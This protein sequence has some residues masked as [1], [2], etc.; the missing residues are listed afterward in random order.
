MDDIVITDLSNRVLE[1]L[2]RSHLSDKTIWEYKRCGIRPILFFFQENGWAA[3]SAEAVKDL[4]MREWEKVKAGLLPRY[5]WSILRR[6]SVYLEQMSM[7]GILHRE[8]LPKWE[9]EIGINPLW[10]AADTSPER[11]DRIETVIQLTRDEVWKLDLGEKAKTNYLFS[12]F[13]IILKYFS[14]QGQTEYSQ[15][16]L[17]TCVRDVRTRFLKGEVGRSSFQCVRKTANW[18]QEYRNTGAITHCRLTNAAFTYTNPEYEELLRE[19]K[20]YMDS[21][22]Y[23]K[24]TT[25][26]V[27]VLEVRRFFRDL[28]EL[29]HTDYASLCLSDVNECIAKIVKETE[30]SIFM[31][32]IAMRSFASFISER[33]P[34][35]PDITPA[36]NCT[37]VRHRRV[38]EGYTDEEA[39]KILNAIDR[40]CAQGKRDYA[41]IMIAY[42]TGMR[43]IDIV[44][45]RFS[46]IDWNKREF[47]IVQEKTGKPLALPFDT[48][49]G[50][51]I[52]DYI[53]NA[54][55]KCDS[56]YVFIRTVRPYKK[57]SGMW[58]IVNVYA[59]AALGETG[60]MNGPHSFRRGMGQRLIEAGISGSVVCDVMGHTSEKS[61]LQYTSASMESLRQCCRTL[62]EIPVEQ[63]AL[64]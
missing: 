22:G 56:E 46:S 37:P 62:S 61:L 60:K 41:M 31:E 24:E 26:K 11:A 63:E 50:N 4:V 38:Y 3:Y 52:A 43:G 9:V 54:R 7:D 49:V 15:E 33:H 30:C 51:A 57:L 53:L 47:H 28:E 21:A 39:Q 13:G 40:Q 10:Q 2:R 59:R 17:D 34:E 48:V 58:Q 23:L 32:L 45:L 12:G 29:G 16:T 64:V 6:V 55:P 19:Y 44:G 5:R 18:I 8:C 1:E 35:L 14:D 25:R 20:E 27:R 42:S 36:L